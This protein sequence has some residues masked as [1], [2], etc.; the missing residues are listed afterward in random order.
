MNIILIIIC[1]CLLVLCIILFGL[2]ILKKTQIN[3]FAQEIKKHRKTEYKTPITVDSF[4]SDIINL[5]NELNEQI[6]IQQ[7]LA[8]DYQHQE[9][10]LHDIIVGISHDFRTPLTATNGYLQM[11][12]KSEKLNGTEKEYLEI[13]IKKTEYMKVLSDDFFE[14]TSV[15]KKYKKTEYANI[16]ICSTMTECLLEHY[17]KITS[18]NLKTEFNIS[19]KPII[20][21]TNEHILKRIFE[22]LISNAEKYAERSIKAEL[23]SENNILTIRISNDIKNINLIDTA[24]VFEP[25]YR[26]KL[27]NENSNGIGL[28][29]VKCLSESLDF[30][31]SADIDKKQNFIITL[32]KITDKSFD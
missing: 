2:L 31:V 19:E 3:K 6:K 17:D 24:K 9:Q 21:N 13:A 18:L 29:V 11:I 8:L 32:K 25:F 1:I 22:N 27:K 20:I 12:E 16:N 28:Y 4:S 26:G 15:Q 23:F 30:D 5:A 7:K 14:I 10:Q